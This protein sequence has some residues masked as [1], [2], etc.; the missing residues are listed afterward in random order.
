MG[1]LRQ[2]MRQRTGMRR[3]WIVV[4][5]AVACAGLAGRTSIASAESE[6]TPTATSCRDLVRK[7]TSFNNA[8]KNGLGQGSPTSIQQYYASL[9]KT[10]RK[11][12]RSGP[13]H[14]RSAFK[15][16]AR[17]MAQVAHI[18]FSNPSSAQQA[19]QQLAASAQQLQPDIQKI[20]A[21]LAS[22]CHYTTTTT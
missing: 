8:R 22:V 19:G 15:H 13:N 12:A 7:Y 10:Y 9:A 14:L 16:L 17:Y 11:L 2:G 4:A 5:T 18:D 21:Y 20:A 1:R 6:N 3:L